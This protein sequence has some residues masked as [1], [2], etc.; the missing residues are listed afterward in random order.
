MNSKS[1]P[2]HDEA[3]KPQNL[4][5]WLMKSRQSN[6]NLRL[7]SSYLVRSYLITTVNASDITSSCSR[8]KSGIFRMRFLNLVHCARA[9]LENYAQHTVLLRTIRQNMKHTRNRQ[10]ICVQ[11]IILSKYSLENELIHNC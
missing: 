4:G 2:E 11:I 3:I 8:P 10:L 5:P 9:E 1:I 6:F 7:P